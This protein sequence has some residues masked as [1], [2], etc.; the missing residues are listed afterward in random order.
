MK[1]GEQRRD[2]ELNQVNEILIL[3]EKKAPRRQTELCKHLAERNLDTGARYDK[4]KK[5]PM[6]KSSSQ[7]VTPSRLFH[8][9]RLRKFALPHGFVGKKANNADDIPN[10]GG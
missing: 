6:V 4:E 7:K 5:A 9:K 1:E 2:D 3:R 8:M 10:F